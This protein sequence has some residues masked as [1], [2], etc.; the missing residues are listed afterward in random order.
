MKILIFFVTLFRIKYIH[1]D[2]LFFLF[3]FWGGGVCDKNDQWSNI[4]KT[5]SQDDVSKLPKRTQVCP[6]STISNIALPIHTGK[7]S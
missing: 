6:S 2:Q 5:K 3:F 7:L 4:A 1:H